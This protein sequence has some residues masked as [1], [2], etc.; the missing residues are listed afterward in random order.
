M[1]TNTQIEELRGV[2]GKLLSMMKVEEYGV[3]PQSETLNKIM[4]LFAHQLELSKQKFTKEQIKA[5]KRAY[6]QGWDSAGGECIKNQQEIDQLV[7]EA[8]ANSW[9]DGYYK[10]WGARKD[11]VDEQLP[12]S[13]DTKGQTSN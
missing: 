3:V 11:N 5:E 10:G 13:Q 6:K 12:L 1:T 2:V 8:A 9:K 7:Q 4:D